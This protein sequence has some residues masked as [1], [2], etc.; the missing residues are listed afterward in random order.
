VQ[1]DIGGN[2]GEG[3]K[4]KPGQYFVLKFDFSTINASPNLEKA[5]QNVIARLNSSIKKFYKAYAAYLG[6]DF[7]DLCQ[8]IDSTNPENSLES[9]AGLVQEALSRAQEQKNEQL[10]GVRGIYVLID[11]YDA[12][13][14][15]YLESLNPVGPCGVTLENS[16]VDRTFKS[17]WSTMKSLSTDEWIRKVFITGISPLSLSAFGSAFN[18]A[19]NLSFH[20]K[21]A[22][23]CGLTRSDLEDVL[24]E[25]KDGEATNH[26]S[27][28]TKFFNGYHFCWNNKVETV[29]NTET[30][31][32]Y[33][34]SIIDGGVLQ[35]K[36]W[37]PAVT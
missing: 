30:C 16:E 8:Y 35:T 21:L 4:Y 11:E 27:E 36:A 1:S 3:E 13:T 33:F 31:L 10:I 26:L 18:V 19:R 37:R 17:F 23:L 7:A 28:M 32:D 20:Q 12:F 29:Y 25:I 24:R 9:C 5:N 34:Q 22:G 15:G 14:N 6:E 2:N